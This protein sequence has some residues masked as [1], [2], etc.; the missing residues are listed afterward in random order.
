MTGNI[1]TFKVHDLMYVVP[2]KAEKHVSYGELDGTTKC[3][4]S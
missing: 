3:V 4:M 2:S 1:V